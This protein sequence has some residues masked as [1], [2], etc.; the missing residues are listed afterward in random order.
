MR[1]APARLDPRWQFRSRR[2]DAGLLA[3]LRDAGSLTA[4][5]Q[6]LAGGRLQVRVEKLGWGRPTLAERRALGLPLAERALLREVVLCAG[7]EDWVVASSVIP[8]RT[9][10]G[11]NRRLARLGNRPL[12]AF[13]FR[14]PSLARTQVV[15]ER[16]ARGPHAG[17]TGRRSTFILRG[18]PLLVAEYFLPALLARGRPPR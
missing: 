7:G 14:D 18:H 1:R 6:V 2:P 11:A 15:I 10:T 4:R 9:L 5:L 17:C 3:W 16:L 13:Q 8:R 12:G